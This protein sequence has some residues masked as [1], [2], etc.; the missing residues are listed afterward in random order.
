VNFVIC[1]CA[2]NGNDSG[3]E[4]HLYAQLAGHIIPEFK[5]IG[6]V[7]KQL[8]EDKIRAGVHLFLQMPPVGVFAFLAGDVAFGKTG[9][10]DGKI[11]R[12]ADEFD[13]LRGKLETAGCGLEIRR[14]RAGRRA[15]RGCFCS[16][17]RGFF[18]SSSRT[19]SRVW[20]TQVRCASAVRP[21]CRWM[22]STIISVLSRVLPPAP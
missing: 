8:G 5:I 11:A 13:Q 20:L 1:G 6:I 16:R 22:R 4:R 21:C 7:E 15:G 2:Q 3:H 17:G 18:P 19:S 10:A 9:D 12:F 14:R